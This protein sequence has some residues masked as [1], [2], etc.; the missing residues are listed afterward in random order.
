M[1]LKEDASLQHTSKS[2]ETPAES[3]DS[4][5]VN[6]PKSKGV[7]RGS[8][9][10][11]IHRRIKVSHTRTNLFRFV[12]SEY[13][14]IRDFGKNTHIL[15]PKL[16]PPG[17]Q[18]N[19]DIQSTFAQYLQP[20]SIELYKV[21][22][23]ILKKRWAQIDRKEYNLLII[24]RKLCEKLSLT[25]FNLLKSTDRDL[26]DR[27]RAIEAYFLLLYSDPRY[28]ELIASILGRVLEQDPVFKKHI[29]ILTTLM[30]KILLS[31][32]ETPS[33]YN[34]LLGLNMIKYRRFF[35]LQDLIHRNCS[36]IVDGDLIE[37]EQDTQREISIFINECR[38]NLS[39]L[40]KKKLDLERIRQFLPFDEENE[41][42]Y[43]P[44]QYL[45]ES[46]HP[47]EVYSYY[48]DQEDVV[49]FTVRI[50]RIFRYSFENLFCDKINLY[51][52]GK[53]SIFPH[54]YFKMEIDKIDTLIE[55]L[56]NISYDYTNPISLKQYLTVK[57]SQSNTSKLETDVL[58]LLDEAVDLLYGLGKKVMLS[59][60]KQ[61]SQK[62]DA[63]KELSDDN[64]VL[65]VPI[66]ARIIAKRSRF[67]GTSVEE[68]LTFMINI[69]LL[70][71]HLYHG[72]FTYVLLSKEGVINDEISSKMEILSRIADADVFQ[73]IE[74]GYRETLHIPYTSKQSEESGQSE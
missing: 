39:F 25:N 30:N 10:W 11:E 38:K 67:P 20:Q 52:Y 26:I 50:L 42:D 12:F 31:D 6:T 57:M 65:T 37:Y 17:I 54:L 19:R 70:I 27:L 24:L 23:H 16:F 41:V 47:E 18:L 7:K 66:D 9:V 28:P 58:L 56:E 8:K 21:L 69:C 44:L 29:P 13:S 35:R 74:K 46:P 34:F 51:G 49:T 62:D 73:E 60:L 15:F 3:R 68:A 33:L 5:P 22:T 40:F 4:P 43:K 61:Q 14:K 53:V 71:N 1:L 2:K 59:V 45:Y 55:Q 64:G 32:I 63:L 72:R 36:N 48:Q